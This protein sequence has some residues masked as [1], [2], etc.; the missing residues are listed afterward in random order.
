M[1][2][3]GAGR[4][5]RSERGGLRPIHPS[6]TVPYH[7]QKQPGGGLRHL[8]KKGENAMFE[9]LFQKHEAGEQ[10]VIVLIRQCIGAARRYSVVERLQQK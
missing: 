9:K 2:Q 5:N 8:L 7:R 3:C 10:E 4:S 1:R 6:A